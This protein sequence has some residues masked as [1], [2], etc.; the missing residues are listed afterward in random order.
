MLINASQTEADTPCVICQK[1]KAEI[2]RLRFKREIS[3]VRRL[4]QP[5]MVQYVDTGMTEEL[6]Y[7][8]MLIFT[9]STSARWCPMGSR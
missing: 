7:L 8:V 4:N 9:E 6:F 3:S 1:S 5:A 2:E